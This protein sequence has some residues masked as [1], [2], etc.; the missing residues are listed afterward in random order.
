MMPESVAQTTCGHFHVNPD[1][2]K[3]VSSALR[4]VELSFS[5]ASRLTVQS[6]IGYF[7]CLPFLAGKGVEAVPAFGS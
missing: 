4:P 7:S 1:P 2:S 3:P 5:E 6:G